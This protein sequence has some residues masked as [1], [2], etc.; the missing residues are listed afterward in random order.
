MGQI[1][2]AHKAMMGMQNPDENRISKMSRVMSLLQRLKLFG[3]YFWLGRQ[4][5]QVPAE[6]VSV[7]EAPP[8]MCKINTKAPDCEYWICVDLFG[9]RFVSVDSAPGHGFQR[10][11]LFNEEAV[12]R[13]LCWGA[14]QNIV[15]FVAS[16]V[17]PAQPT[18]G[19]VPMTIALISPAAVDIAYAVHVIHKTSAKHR[20]A[21][22]RYVCSQFGAS[23]I[24]GTDFLVV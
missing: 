20:F 21:S 16:T 12:E 17:N 19:R 14:R 6:K 24:R 11:F 8:Q 7:P 15:Q 5:M 23:K 1:L 22:M 2:D 4:T 18:A 3:A 10:G 13:V 9:V